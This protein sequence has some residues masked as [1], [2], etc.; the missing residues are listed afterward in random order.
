MSRSSSADSS[1]SMAARDRSRSPRRATIY[2]TKPEQETQTEVTYNP[3]EDRFEMYKDPIH[4]STCFLANCYIFDQ[5]L[6]NTPPRQ[7]ISDPHGVFKRPNIS[8]KKEY[9]GLHH[10]GRDNWVFHWAVDPNNHHWFLN[11]KARDDSDLWAEYNLVWQTIQRTD[12]IDDA[13]RA[14]RLEHDLLP[15]KDIF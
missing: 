1:K 8:W 9:T 2:P 14:L 4:E 6:I 7:L 5:D 11:I 15:S 12:T 10:N 13:F 3:M